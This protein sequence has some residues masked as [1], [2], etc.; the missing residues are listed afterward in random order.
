[1]NAEIKKGLTAKQA[2]DLKVKELRE[3][4]IPPSHCLINATTFDLS[5]QSYSSFVALNPQE[6][7]D[8]N[9]IVYWAEFEPWVV[10]TDVFH[11]PLSRV[12]SVAIKDSLEDCSKLREVFDK[13]E[14][15]SKFT[16][17][18]IVDISPFRDI[19]LLSQ[20][21]D[22]NIKARRSVKEKGELKIM[23]DSERILHAQKC[24]IDSGSMC[25][26]KQNSE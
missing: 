8:R 22:R 14:V 20:F 16:F 2:L 18:E 12:K 5:G 1:M 4:G 3:S 21:I 10:W 9:A 19:S 15:Y 11:K 23:T 25:S 17:A 7:E 24:Y 13:F 26:P 6:I